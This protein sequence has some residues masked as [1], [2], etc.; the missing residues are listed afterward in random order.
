MLIRSLL[1]VAIVAATAFG[2]VSAPHPAAPH[3]T[4]APNASETTCDFDGNGHNDLAVGV[5]GEDNRGAVN[6]QRHD[7]TFVTLPSIIRAPSDVE[8]GSNFGAALSCGDFDHDGIDDL[9]I[10]APKAPPGG[11]VYIYWGDKDRPLGRYDWFSQNNSHIPGQA[12]HGELFGFSLET[13]D[14]NADGRDDLAVGIPRDS[15][16][17][18]DPHKATG[19][20]AVIYGSALGWNAG[21]LGPVSLLTSWYRINPLEMSQQMFGWSLAAA[22]LVSGEGDDLAVGAPFT[23]VVAPGG[24][25]CTFGCVLEAGRVYLLR[26]QAD[27]LLPYNILDADDFATPGSQTGAHFGVSLATG[28]FN[29]D[30]QVGLAIGAPHYDVPGANAAGLVYVAHGSPSGPVP[31]YE[32]VLGASEAGGAMEAADWFGTSLAAGDF[33]VDGI[34]DLAIG[35]PGEDV[36]AGPHQVK[37]AGAVFVVHGTTSSR[38]P[39]TRHRVLVQGKQG[40]P[41][42]SEVNDYFGASLAVLPLLSYDDLVIGTPGED[43]PNPALPDSNNAGQVTIAIGYPHLGPVA[44]AALTMN[45]DTGT[46]YNVSSAR[47][48]APIEMPQGPLN[49]YDA[50]GFGSGEWFGWSIGQ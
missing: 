43:G 45:Q 41:G 13:G 31:S 20:V 3:R 42:V 25:N 7:G 6:I 30:G 21:P 17:S 48:V 44:D 14:F 12:H 2:A 49:V 27:A 40:V 23:A 39:W 22:P 8:G 5:P 34:D 10:G 9:A 24:S 47:E 19:T 4:A 50:A 33:D 15:D 18:D 16:P 1:P 36:G 38:H 26:S 11:R 35:C 28:D 32:G 29:G 46:P 37:N